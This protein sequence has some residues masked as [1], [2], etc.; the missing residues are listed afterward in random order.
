MMTS[1][2]SAT[3]LNRAARFWY[4]VT[5]LGMWLFVYYIVA[6]Y[7]G[8]TLQGDFE[9]WNANQM[10]TRGHVPGDVAGNLMI[11]GH[12]LLSAVLTLGGTIQLVP[13]L[14]RRAL[15]LHRWNGRLFMVAA[16]LVALA[17]LGLNVLRGDDKL[18]GSWPSPID[19]NGVLILGFA[20][21][22]WIFARGGQIAAHRRWALRTFMVVSG[23]WFLRLGASIWIL[24]TAA[25]YGQP[26]L[27]SEFFSVWSWGCFLFPLAVLEVYFW[28]QKQNSPK[29]RY[30]VA[31]LLVILTLLTAVGIFAAYRVFWSPLL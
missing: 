17:G 9:A 5:A 29:P 13:Q 12:I 18:G 28:S 22:A 8:P 1:I 30:L 3:A 11:A 4:L 23:V 10:L 31:A 25:M 2:D 27:V 15:A 7:Y 24:A 19:F 6:F 20:V 21:A 14:R 16:L 26:S